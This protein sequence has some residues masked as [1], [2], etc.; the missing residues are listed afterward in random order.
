MRRMKIFQF[1]QNDGEG[2]RYILDAKPEINIV[3]DSLS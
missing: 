1:P 2:A 3:N